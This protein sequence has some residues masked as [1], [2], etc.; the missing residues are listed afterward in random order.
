VSSEDVVTDK[1]LLAYERRRRV[2]DVG[3][4]L[5]SSDNLQKYA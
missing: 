4:I 3:K 2:V 1:I 5:S